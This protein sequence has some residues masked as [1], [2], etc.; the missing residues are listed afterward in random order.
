MATRT[1]DPTE[2]DDLGEV[3]DASSSCQRCELY[4]GASQ[5]VFGTGPTTAWLVLL[6]EQPGDREDRAGEPFVGPAG[7]L[8]DR[9]LEDAGIE[10]DATYLTN[11]VKHFKFEE[12]GKRRIHQ[13][14]NASEIRACRPWLDAELRLIRPSVLGLLGATAAQALLG[15]SFRITKHR[16]EVLPCG[17]H[18]TAV[19]TVHPSSI[20]RL[21]DE[22]RQEAYSALVA[23]LK[24]IAD[25]APAR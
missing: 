23:D 17:D 19:P 15:S 12:R 3:R 7:R 13:K 25:Q 16:G 22:Q 6:G 8:L 10:R 14:P 4:R 5:T 11:A 9:A 1:P 21:P 2:L 20:L 18:L 24:V